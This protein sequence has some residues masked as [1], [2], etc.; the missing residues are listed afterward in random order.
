MEYNLRPAQLGDLQRIEEI[1]A[2]ARAF[3]AKNGN[4]NQWGNT[5]PPTEQLI[6]DVEDGNLYVMMEEQ[7]IH[8]VFYFRIG[9]DPTYARIDDGAWRSDSP[10]GTIH[11]IAG[12][13]SGGI[14]KTAV[15]F[16][17]KQ[18]G[19]LRI[20]T[21]EDNHVMRRAVKKLGFQ[22]CGIIYLA[23]GSQRIAFD[24]LAQDS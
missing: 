13:G 24:W 20:D 22:R 18:I 6:Q 23:D 4:P 11:R 19:H 3:M 10:Y 1:Y 21:H 2:Y 12:D 9:P 5:E 15:D 16:G 8:G 17:R 7:Q 14:L